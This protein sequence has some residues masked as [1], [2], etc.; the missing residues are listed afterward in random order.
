MADR[1]HP[2]KLEHPAYGTQTD[3]TPTELDPNEDHVSTRG[4]FLQNDSSDDEVA[5]LT[6]DSSNRMTFQDADNVTPVTLTSLIGAADPG[7]IEPVGFPNRDDS[8]YSFNPTTR[9]FTISPTGSSYDFYTEG[10]VKYTKTTDQTTVIPDTEGNHF[11]YFDTS[12]VL[13]NTM[14]WTDDLVLKYAYV[15]GLYWDADN[16]EAILLGEERHGRIMSGATHLHW[17][18]TFGTSYYSGLGLNSVLTD[19]DGSSDTH[20]QLGT[21]S[22]YFADEDIIHAVAAK[23]APA[24]IAVVYRSGAA[25]YWRRDTPTNFPVKP[26][27]SGRVAWNEWTGS[28]WQQT[29]ASNNSYVCCHL[30]L[31]NDPDQW[32]WSIQGQAEYGNLAAAQ[33]GAKTELANLVLNG[34]PAAEFLAAATLIVQTANGYSNAIKGRF[35]S[36]DEGGDW[37]D[38]RSAR[39]NPTSAPVDTLTED[40]HK[41]LR[42]LIHFI[43]EGP[44]ENF[45]SA[46]Y[47]ETLPSASVF[48]TS[49]IWWESSSK[50]KKIVERT[51]TW[52]GVNPTTDQW[53]VYDL[54]GSTVRA[55]VSD[56]ISYSGVF[57]TTRT[58]TIT[59]S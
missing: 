16:N 33:Q 13:Q 2:L 46:A 37:L 17:H 29:Q 12:G 5:H 3:F 7:G 26:Y 28:T 15:V 51:I 14:T 22:G 43:E 57:E 24:Q 21:D 40:Q 8:E 1:V 32:W 30:F 36:T 34:L 53:D 38:W 39:I 56:A 59:V 55:T 4:V 54:D 58:R 6:R 35:R 31:I 49:V 19:E 45:D 9:T 27:P 52:T 50:L 11:I 20:C 42:H 10:G 23:T 48:P 25:G 44:A 18:R 47:K 41:A